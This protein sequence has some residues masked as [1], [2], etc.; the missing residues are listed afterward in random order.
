MVI[1]KELNCEL[2]AF[3]NFENDE[4]KCLYCKI[5]KKQGMV[6]LKK[7]R[8]C[9]EEFCNKHPNFNFE[10]EKYPDYCNTHKK[11]NMIDIKNKRCKEENCI[12]SPNFNLPDKKGGLYCFDNKSDKMIDVC[13]KRCL[14]KDCEIRPKFNYDGKKNGIYCSKHKLENMINV[15][16][17]K[18]KNDCGTQLE[19]MKYKHYCLRCFINLF[20]NETIS[21][22]YKVKEIYMTDFIKDQF[23]DE[24]MIFDKTVGACSRRRPDCYI[25]KFTHVIIVECDENQ[26]RETS[27]ENKRMM[28]LFQDFGNRPIIFIRF[29]PDTYINEQNKKI[30]SSFK[31]HNKL[32]VP[33]I[34]NKEE[35]D[36]RLDLLKITINKWLITIPN[37]EITIE[38]LFFDKL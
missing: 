21:R 22:N 11:D 8:I 12:K 29:N 28:E 14:E 30:V 15:Y 23:K 33:L 38:K 9:I 26:H 37:K 16:A 35:W 27:C 4:W 25:D 18:C 10:D 1:C 32:G 3:Y 24:V 2:R 31:Y 13:S 34:R 19:T 6:Y 7:R 5:H 17:I 20:P 36:N